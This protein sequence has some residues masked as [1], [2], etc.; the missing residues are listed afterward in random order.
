MMGIKCNCLKCKQY[1][2]E[3]RLMTKALKSLNRL[4]KSKCLG[5]PITLRR[6]IKT[7]RLVER[8]LKGAY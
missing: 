5:E 3:M 7:R 8:A 4:H 1:Q 2:A 6:I